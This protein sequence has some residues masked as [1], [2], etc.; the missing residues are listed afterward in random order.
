MPQPWCGSSVPTVSQ[1]KIFVEIEAIYRQRNSKSFGL[2]DLMQKFA[3][4]GSVWKHLGRNIA[5][6]VRV[7]GIDRSVSLGWFRVPEYR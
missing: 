1:H 4:W 2:T 3:T 6:T 7:K 5:S